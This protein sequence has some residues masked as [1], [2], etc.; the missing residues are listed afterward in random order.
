[1]DLFIVIDSYLTS[2][3]CL[4]SFRYCRLRKNAFITILALR[5]LTV[6][7]SVPSFSVECSHRTP[8]VSCTMRPIV[9]NGSSR[10]H[11]RS[12]KCLVGPQYDTTRDSYTDNERSCRTRSRQR[13]VSSWQGLPRPSHISLD[14][15][16]DPEKWRMVSKFTVDLE[17][18]SPLHETTCLSNWS[19]NAR[20][21]CR[22]TFDLSKF[23]LT[24]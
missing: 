1:M 24:T 22:V 7:S 14:L 15:R 21:P 6:T 13:L 10:S 4:R 5:S 8:V 17:E 2:S 12:V 18:P 20:P 3:F 23:R 11:I 9:K 16:L 19:G